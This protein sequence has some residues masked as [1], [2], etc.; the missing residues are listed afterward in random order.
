MDNDTFERFTALDF[1]SQSKRDAS[2]DLFGTYK[3]LNS[4]KVADIDVQLISALR[5]QHPELIVT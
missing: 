2:E 4:G 1:A 3:D 5:A